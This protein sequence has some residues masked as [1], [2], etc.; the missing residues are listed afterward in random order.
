M[1]PL[2]YWANHEWYNEAMAEP[3]EKKKNSKKGQGKK[4]KKKKKKPCS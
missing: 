4:K 2:K 3:A 1:M